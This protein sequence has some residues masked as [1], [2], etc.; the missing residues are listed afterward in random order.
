MDI[1]PREKSDI[2]G[3]RNRGLKFQREQEKSPNFSCSFPGGRAGVTVPSRQRSL[4]VR[5]FG[6]G[7]RQTEVADQYPFLPAV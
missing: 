3:P 4:T 6:P 5:G 2:S 7:V 1:I